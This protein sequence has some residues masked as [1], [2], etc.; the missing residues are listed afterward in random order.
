MTWLFDLVEDHRAAVKYDLIHHGRHLADL[1]TP[2]LSWGDAFTILT[3]QPADRSAVYRE[4]HPDEYDLSSTTLRL[5]KIA[6]RLEAITVILV[7]TQ[8]LAG[9]QTAVKADQ[10]PTRFEQLFEEVKPRPPRELL[11]IEEVHAR[12]ARIGGEAWQI[13]LS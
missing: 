4:T 9:N 1:G 2:R 5:D 13:A 3:M 6:Q 8:L 10:L 12:M 11:S 7:Q